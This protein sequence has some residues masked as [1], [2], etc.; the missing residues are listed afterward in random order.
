MKL[1]EELQFIQNNRMPQ[2]TSSARMDGKVCVI[3][4]ATS[5]VGYEAAKALAAGGAALVLVN[6]SPEKSA[7]VQAELQNAYGCPVETVIADFRSLAQVSR[8]ADSVAAKYPQVHVLINNAGVFNKRR[9]L[10]QDGFEEVFGV[11]HL[12]AF[13]LTK[14]LLENLKA[15]APSRVIAVS[16]EAHRFGGLSLKDLDWSKRPYIGLQAYGAAK[17]AQLLT[18]LEFTQRTAGSGVTFNAMH[19]GAVRTNLGMNNNAF[20]RF[21]N[22]HIIGWTFKDA[23]ISGSA[24]YYLASA[25]E[26]ETVSGKFYNLTIEE[27]PAAYAVRPQLRQPVW[28]V[29]EASVA[30][31]LNAV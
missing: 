12:A 17:T 13:L 6:R 21:Y 5:G 30:P 19:P 22:R 15:G 29:S 1:P 20:Y 10:T 7:R 16:S 2:K 27:A 25:P 3:T 9:K 18:M 31:F 26:L 14:K 24:L 28:D 23:A 8:A 4:G 11:F